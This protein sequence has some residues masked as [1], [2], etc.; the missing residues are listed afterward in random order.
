VWL[1][2]LRSSRRELNDKDAWQLVSFTAKLPA[3]LPGVLFT[4]TITGWWQAAPGSDHHCREAVVRSYLRYIASQVASTTA[5]FDADAVQ[6]AINVVLAARQIVPDDPSIQ[7]YGI[8]QLELLGAD[9][10]AVHRQC[11]FQREEVLQQEK[12]RARLN[13]LREVFADRALMQLWWI[14]NHPDQL[15]PLT[16]DGMLDGVVR[17]VQTSM[18]QQPGSAQDRIVQIL[19]SVA[20]KCEGPDERRLFLHVFEQVLRGSGFS[21]EAAEVRGIRRELLPPDDPGE[22]LLATPADEHRVPPQPR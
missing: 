21:E 11:Q 18:P 19:A 12:E 17:T 15:G 7:T 3:A 9:A 10:D 2:R 1:K 13:F 6:D 20:Q 5:I 4:A 16:P 8:V 22:P 14:E